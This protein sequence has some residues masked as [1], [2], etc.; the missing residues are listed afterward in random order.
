M[1]TMVS[2][3]HLPHATACALLDRAAD[4]IGLDDSMHRVLREIERELIVH[5]PVEMDDGTFQV[6]TGFRVHHNLSR[7]P[8]KGGLRYHPDMTLDDARALAMYMTWKTAVV[9]L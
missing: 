1:P 6:F 3:P 2:G 5:F 4:Q 9:V 7:G 8:A